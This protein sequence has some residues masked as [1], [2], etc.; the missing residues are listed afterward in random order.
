MGQLDNE[1]ETKN[2]LDENGWMHSGDKGKILENG[3][4]QITGRFKELI[5]TAGGE[6]IAP[7]LIESQ[8]KE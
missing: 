6:N 7:I 4:C 5:I 8:M 2:A 1:G 3:Q